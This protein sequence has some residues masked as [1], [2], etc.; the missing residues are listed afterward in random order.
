[1]GIK[2]AELGQRRVLLRNRDLDVVARRGLVQR[3][4]FHAKDGLGL[5]I[6]SVDVKHTGARTV[7]RRSIV[8]GARRTLG[9]EGLDLAHS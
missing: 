5:Q 8:L 1:M 9:P 3:Q 7:G 6:K 4:R 2:A